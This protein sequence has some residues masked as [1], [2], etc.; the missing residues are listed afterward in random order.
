MLSS[1]ISVSAQETTDF[2]YV[3]ENKTII[4]DDNT[5]LSIEQQQKIA[6]RLAN[7]ADGVSTYNLWCTLWGHKY[8]TTEGATVIQHEVNPTAPRCLK[9]YF[10]VHICSRCEESGQIE[11]LGSEYIFCC[12]E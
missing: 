9:E 10:L 12:P 11:S 4:F 1:C 8:D 5:T 2:T 3:Y 6:D 7:G